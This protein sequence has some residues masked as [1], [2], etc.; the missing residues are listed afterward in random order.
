M[1]MRKVNG[2]EERENLDK[3]KPRNWISRATVYGDNYGIR[4]TMTLGILI[5]RNY[6]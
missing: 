2:E 1:E 5:D 3:S 6:G 4:Q